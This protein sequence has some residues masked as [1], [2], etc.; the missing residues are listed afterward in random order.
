MTI[1]KSKSRK[2]LNLK[3]AKNRKSLFTF[4]LSSGDH[5]SIKRFFFLTDNISKFQFR[6]ENIIV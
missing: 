6:I 3:K 5:A 2:L 1:I 4:L